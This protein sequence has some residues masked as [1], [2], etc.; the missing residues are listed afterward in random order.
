MAD[1][2]ALSRRALN[3]GFGGLGTPPGTTGTNG[4]AGSPATQ[5]TH[6]GTFI[7]TLWAKGG[8]VSVVAIVS[9]ALKPAK[10]GVS[11][12]FAIAATGGKKPYHWSMS[13][14]A[15]PKGLAL[16]TTTGLIAGKPKTKGSYTFTVAVADSSAPAYMD[17]RMFT[18][19]VS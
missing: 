1:S 15:L 3:G 5:G 9:S 4:T 6:G 11:Y 13:K 7:R 10:H 12:K 19:K 17:T 16:S 2:A 18:L 8:T 14:G